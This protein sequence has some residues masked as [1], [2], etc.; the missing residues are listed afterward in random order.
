[1]KTLLLILGL[2]L[3]GSLA[4]LAQNGSGQAL[5]FNGSSQFADCGN[6]NL[7]GSAIT[8]QAWVNVDQFKTTS[9]F[10]TSLIGTEQPGHQ[11]MIRL[12]DGNL[13][14]EKVQ[15][16]L[17]FGSTH[18]K[19]NGSQE[20]QTNKWY[21]IAATY[22]G[23][24]MKIYIN[25]ILDVSNS[26]SGSF[27]S[28]ST[29]EIGRGYAN[30]RI[31]DGEIDEVSVFTEAL[32]QA[33][34]RD[35]M[36]RE[37]TAQH[38]NYSALEGYWQLNEGS[39]NS[40]TDASGNGYTGSLTGGP[41]RRNSGAPIGQ[42]SKHNYGSSFNL[43]LGHTQGD[44]MNFSHNSGTMEAAHIYLVDE[45]P[46]VT[47]VPAP[48]NFMD[49]S[50]YWGVFV[51]G[52]S[53]YTVEHHYN[54][55]TVI[56]NNNDC[57][58][59]Y[60]R[61][62]S[63]AA[64]NWQNVSVGNSDYTNNIADWTMSGRKEFAVAISN[65]GPHSIGFTQE[66]PSCEGGSD[67]SL[68]ASTTGGTA[69]YTYLWSSGG[70]N[71]TENGL[72]AG[73]YSVTVTDDNG[74]IS[75]DSVEL[76][77]PNAVGISTNITPASCKLVADGEIT[78]NPAGGSGSG[79]TF[80]WDDPNNSTT[81]TVSGLLPGIYSI[82]VMDGN[83]CTSV[84]DV[85][86]TSTGPDPIVD[87][88][89]DV[90]ACSIESY[91]LSA[92]VEN[93]PAQSYNWSTGAS[94]PSITVTEDGEYILSVTNNSGCIGLDTINVAFVEP[95]PINLGPNITSEVSY[96]LTAPVG[97]TNYTWSNGAAG[98]SI[99]ITSTGTYTVIAVDSN[100]CNTSDDIKITIVPAGI[101]EINASKLRVW[102]NP[103]TSSITIDSPINGKLYLT[104]LSGRAVMKASVQAGNYST[105]ELKNIDSGSYLLTIQGQYD[106]LN[107]V[108]VVNP[109]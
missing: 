88:G 51:V 11:A 66:E 62:S 90:K 67:G 41:N 27:T 5:E 98:I 18:V 6:I 25:G 92:T 104:D 108:V 34:I 35:W 81:S 84:Y 93:G 97:F 85:E 106:A 55:N 69:P 17:L 10:I 83:G 7:S 31:I 57:N 29:F 3:S 109:K 44:S 24:S 28:N 72:A 45:A 26:T 71:A 22:D 96:T 33:T 58:L 16:I 87:L 63:G 36:C 73:V 75:S 12:G 78:V 52:S 95:V 86:L 49:S 2:S 20:L 32:D 13:D 21:H 23:S 38:P 74:C 19:L 59:D 94:S 102:P 70:T 80:L 4:A 101:D 53:N 54:G 42:R 82:T 48:L 43:G 40:L 65:N 79:Y 30:S 50:H 61:R 46:Y 56:A 100:G 77:E 103:S 91:S 99:L 14:P 60:A 47:N 39:G 1:M 9:P 89:D 15:F 64:N 105:L 68:T 76:T 8:L 37:I 107:T